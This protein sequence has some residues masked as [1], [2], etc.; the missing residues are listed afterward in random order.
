[1]FDERKI[2]RCC[3]LHRAA[4]HARIHHGFAIVRNRND[5]GL[6]H[7]GNRCQF[8]SRAVFRDRANWEHIYQGGP[9]SAIHNVARDRGAVIH[10]LRVRHAADGSKSTRRRSAG[11]AFNRFGMFEP[12]FAKMDMHVDEPGRD[13]RFGGIEHLASGRRKIYADLANHSVFYP[14]V[15]HT[16]QISRGIDHASV[17]D[18]EPAHAA[19]TLSSTA[20]RTAMPFST[21]FR[22]AERCESATSAEISRPRLIGPGCMTTTLGFASST[23]SGRKPK[24]W[25][26][27]LAGNAASCWRSSCTRSIIITSTPRIARSMSYARLTPGAI[28]SISHGS[29]VA[30]PHRTTCTPNLESRKMLERA[31]RLCAISP[32]IAMRKPSSVP[33]RSRMVRASRSACVGCS[34]VPS[35]ALTIGIG[36]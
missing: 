23:C 21:W 30:G 19:S 34:C 32:I 27:S 14:D 17:L 26:Y 33:S 6:L 20:I 36:R 1:M 24:N 7:R 3:I 22:I 18:H 25:K 28:F 12:R 9:S 11:A 4:G 15:A 10:R 16:V 31:T 29:S 2:Q 5:S 35:P 8:F 13:D